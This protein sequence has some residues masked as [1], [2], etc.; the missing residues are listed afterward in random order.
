M[1]TGIGAS[2]QLNDFQC[3]DNFDVLDEVQRITVPTLIICGADDKM[4]PVKYSV[5]LAQRMPE[6]RVVVI[7]GG[8]HVVFMEKHEEVNRVIDEFVQALDCR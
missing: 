7:G 5:Y 2:V 1:V 6:A 8:S 3:C 4:T